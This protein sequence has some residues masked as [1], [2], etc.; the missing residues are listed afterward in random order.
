MWEICSRVFF[1]HNAASSFKPQPRHDGHSHTIGLGV[2]CGDKQWQRGCVTTLKQQDATEGNNGSLFI[3]VAHASKQGMEPR[4]VGRLHS[5]S[6]VK[7][8][9]PTTVCLWCKY[10][11]PIK[12]L[13]LLP[14]LDQ[15]PNKRA[16]Q[17]L[18]SG[19]FPRDLG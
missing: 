8:H 19:F 2:Q 5:Q 12:L 10:P 16:A 4:H 6:I 14:L 1:A 17:V 15:Y 13:A 18:K 3:N 11:T 9:G 7:S